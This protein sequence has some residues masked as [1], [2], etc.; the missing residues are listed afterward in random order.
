MP[1]LAQALRIAT[2]LGVLAYASS[3]AAFPI[4]DSYYGGDDHHYGDIVGGPVF[5]VQGASIKT[6]MDWAKQEIEGFRR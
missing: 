3:A 1:S 5:D 2:V 4:N 6:V